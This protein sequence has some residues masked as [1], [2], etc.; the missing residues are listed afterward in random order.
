M[1]CNIDEIIRRIDQRIEEIEQEDNCCIQSKELINEVEVKIDD[2]KN[3]IEMGYDQY[4]DKLNNLVGLEEVKEEVKKLINYLIFI[5]KMGNKINLDTINLNM[6]FRG[7]PGTGKT[8]VARIVADILCKLGFLK[9]N[10][11][12]ETTPRDFI[13]GYVGQTA[14]K[15]RKTIDKAAGGVIFIDE[16]YTF[17]QST[18]ESDHTFVYEAITEIIKEME[19]LNTVFI[20]SGYSN[21]MNDF[22]ELNPGIKSRIGYDIEF[23]DYTKDELLLM[24]KNK[25]NKSRMRLSDNAYHVLLEKI[26]ENMSKKNFGNGRFARNLFEKAIERQATRLTTL[27]ERTPEMLKTLEIGDIGLVVKSKQD[28]NNQKQEKGE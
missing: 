26:E 5:K 2:L 10:K 15:A 7:N 12:L 9:T 11:I 25:L 16:A 1:E 23:K 19:T 21:K 22:I 4:M 27:S 14:I 20:F 17:S 8:T 24:F 18:D 3:N 28:A 13:A 6:I